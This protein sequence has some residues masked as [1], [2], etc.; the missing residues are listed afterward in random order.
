METTEARVATHLVTDSD[1]NIVVARKE[2]CVNNDANLT[3]AP[4]VGYQVLD[5]T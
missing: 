3:S 5:V 2:Q 1:L 4:V